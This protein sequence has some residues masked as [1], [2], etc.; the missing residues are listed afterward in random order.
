M[1]I[2]MYSQYNEDLSYFGGAPTQVAPPSNMEANRVPMYNQYTEDMS[3]QQYNYGYDVNNIYYNPY[4]Q[5]VAQ[6]INQP[7]TFPPQPNVMP[8]QQTP[9]YGNLQQNTY[10]NPYMYQQQQR[11]GSVEELYKPP[12]LTTQSEPVQQQI[13][14]PFANNL[15]KDIPFGIPTQEEMD[16]FS[17]IRVAN[18]GE[19][20]KRVQQPVQQPQHPPSLPN[21]K[22]Q[23]FYS[24]SGLPYKFNLPQGA[25]PPVG[26]YQPP[27]LPS[28]YMGSYYSGSLYQDPYSYAAFMKQQEEAAKKQ[29][30]SDAIVRKHMVKAYCTLHG[31]EFTK[32]LEEQIDKEN[33]A[34]ITPPPPRQLE[35]WEIDQNQILASIPYMR[36]C[37]EEYPN[38]DI[39]GMRMQCTQ[40]QADQKRLNPDDIGF[41][42]FCN[43]YAG[44]IITEAELLESKRQRMSKN[45]YYSKENFNKEVEKSLLDE[46]TYCN[47]LEVNGQKF[48]VPRVKLDENGN[49]VLDIKG[50]SPISGVVRDKNGDEWLNDTPTSMLRD[51]ETRRKIF[52]EHCMQGAK[53]YEAK[54]KAKGEH[55]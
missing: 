24:N 31:I 21:D 16:A 7:N 28:G 49:K 14:N 3:V 30:E 9:Q 1:N 36:E 35:Q 55:L 52:Y 10:T 22:T 45:A 29:R 48:Y 8:L 2:P 33:Q 53:E 27:L 13:T 38:A 43:E 26:M 32:E 50:P 37:T 4:Y 51:R 34:Y 17:G 5:Q 23:T 11:Y 47:D 19:G 42:E 20:Y 6:G 25:Q 40:I 46:S 54:L 41:V 39:M 44:L 15:N 18:D 12:S